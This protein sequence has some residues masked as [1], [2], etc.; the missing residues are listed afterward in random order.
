[1]TEMRRTHINFH[2]Q[3]MS[4]RLIVGWISKLGQIFFGE[5]VFGLIKHN[6][7]LDYPRQ[8]VYILSMCNLGHML[9]F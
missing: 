9:S 4:E 5:M 3:V 6:C 1:M 8:T 7:P 2:F